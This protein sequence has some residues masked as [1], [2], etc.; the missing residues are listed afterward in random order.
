MER[1]QAPPGGWGQGAAEMWQPGRPDLA[2]HSGCLV[3][4]PGSLGDTETR[5]PQGPRGAQ[6][7]TAAPRH[8]VPGSGREGCLLADGV[9]GLPGS[10]WSWGLSGG[11]GVLCPVCSASRTKG[12]ALN[13]DGDTTI[14]PGQ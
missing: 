2:L 10:M 7:C 1:P 6:G 3:V 9:A 8:G 5:R 13:Q 14:Y 4:P 12:S 11:L